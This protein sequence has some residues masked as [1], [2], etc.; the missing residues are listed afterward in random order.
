[1]KQVSD[2]RDSLSAACINL[3]DLPVL[4]VFRDREVITVSI[5]GERVWIKWNAGEVS[6][7]DRLLPLNNVELFRNESGKWYKLGSKIPFP[8]V[9]TSTTF[10]SLSSVLFPDQ[11]VWRSPDEITGSLKKIG[12][13]QACSVQKTTALL[14][15]FGTFVE[16]AENA[17]SFEISRLSGVFCDDCVLVL[18]EN[19]PPIPE[20]TRFYG[21][22]VLLP[23]GYQLD[24]ELTD[25]EVRSL[26]DSSQDEIVLITADDAQ[27]I[28]KSLINRL[29][30]SAIRLAAQS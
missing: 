15:P 27:L 6:V 3:Q 25:T 29:T 14:C 22:S 7:V 24:P 26:L 13:K 28:A 23:L 17:S 1:M 4:G 11:I 5:E 30:R 16:W 21:E 18:G 12:L 20:G 2:R 19:V 9:P 8:N 10:V